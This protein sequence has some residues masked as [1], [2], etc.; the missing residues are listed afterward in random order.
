MKVSQ[1]CILTTH[2]NLKLLKKI[3]RL[4]EKITMVK[5]QN[6]CQMGLHHPALPR[7]FKNCFYNM[8][9]KLTYA[10]ITHD[11]SKNIDSQ[12]LPIQNLM[13]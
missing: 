4:E 10:S 2:F 6:T 9:C 7:L 8:V 12:T 13:N 1:D 5:R 3:K 11:V